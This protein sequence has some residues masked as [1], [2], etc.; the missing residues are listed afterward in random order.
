MEDRS[1]W[2]KHSKSKTP[3]WASKITG[4]PETDIVQLAK[5]L[6]TSQPAAIRIG[7][8]LERHHGGGQTIRAVTCI[9][10]LTGA[11]KHVGG[12]ITQFPVWEHP[13]KFD[14]ICRPDWVPENTRVINA[15][16]IGR[17]LTGEIH[18]DIPVKSFMCWNANP[19]TQAPETE[20]II[21]GLMREDIFMVS[22][23]HFIRFKYSENATEVWKNLPLNLL[24]VSK[25]CQDFCPVQKS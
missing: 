17:V 10:A 25:N 8:A 16:Q 20:K 14:V 13:Y 4:I 18:K 3:A 11:W 5:E 12:G 7:V 1:S 22:A 6:A 23:E 24:K 2:T 15:L 19:V 9:P 21:S